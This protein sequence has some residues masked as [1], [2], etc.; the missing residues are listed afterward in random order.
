MGSSHPFSPHGGGGGPQRGAPG[1]AD[2][3]SLTLHL[4]PWARQGC[5]SSLGAGPRAWRV[6][7][8]R[9]AFQDP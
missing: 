4:G 2:S 8:P 3:R 9:E 1:D 6:G 7:G 5:L